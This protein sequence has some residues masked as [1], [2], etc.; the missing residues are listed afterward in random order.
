MT[1]NILRGKK[2]MEPNKNGVPVNTLY[3][4]SI[5]SIIVG[6]L[7]GGLTLIIIGLEVS[8]N[9]AGIWAVFD[10]FNVK[11]VGGKMVHP[12]DYITN[13]G[14]LS[15]VLAFLVMIYP[16]IRI[17]SVSENYTFREAFHG[18]VQLFG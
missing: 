5:T 1:F 11:D 13:F 12:A 4:T 7:W 8:T 16:F 2:K 15:W 3:F 18:N 9:Q 6:L 17:F 10:H 14:M